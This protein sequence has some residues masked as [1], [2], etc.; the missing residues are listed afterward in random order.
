M[1]PCAA[2]ET[3][4]AE[5][6]A[7]ECAAAMRAP[8]KKE[9]ERAQFTLRSPKGDLTAEI[10]VFYKKGKHGIQE[11]GREW[12]SA[13]SDVIALCRLNAKDAVN[14]ELSFN[15]KSFTYIPEEKGIYCDYEHSLQNALAAMKEGKTEAKLITR[16]YAP[17]VTVK[18][19]KER[20]QKLSS[21]TT[22]FD[23]GNLPRVHN[24]ALAAKRIAG[25]VLAPHAEFSFNE[26]VGKRTEQNGFQVANVI[27]GGEFVPGVGGGVCQ[28]STTLMNGALL[29]GLRVTESRPHS[30]PVGYVK[31]SL[32]AMVSEY[33]DLRFINPY[34]FP[35][36]LAAETGTNFVRF[37]FYGKPNGKRYVT[38][39]NVRYRIPPP[40]AEIVEGEE[41][42]II[43]A[44]KD[45]IA[46]ESYLLV[47]DNRGSLISRTLFR[48]DT[49]AAQQGKFQTAPKQE[50]GE[51]NGDTENSQEKNSEIP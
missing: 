20:T 47:Y 21:F 37:I 16:E 41:D 14:A 23:G 49:Y 9:T 31:P 51:E 35:V 13:E 7:V 40:A 12:V 48:R 34:D 6:A 1:A 42:K 32:D 18:M 5:P 3:K 17:E 36:Y 4:A 45:G 44:E 29:A 30:L 8:A 11:M 33:S 19:L 25:T 15:G 39:S 26:R 24:I 28:A 22:Y 50:E 38:E 27:L 10:A 43:R 2:A 46:S